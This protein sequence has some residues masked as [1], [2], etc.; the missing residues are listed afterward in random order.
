MLVW[1]CQNPLS[2]LLANG[3]LLRVSFLSSL[4]ADNDVISGAVHR[5]H[6]ICLMADEDPGKRH[7][8]NC[9]MKSVRPVIMEYLTSKRVQYRTS[10][11]KERELGPHTNLL[12]LL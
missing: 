7:I 6:G 2:G 12:S 10:G 1:R 11:R 9:L 4:S 3:H 5:S 8:G